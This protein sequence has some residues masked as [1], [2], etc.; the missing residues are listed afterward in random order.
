MSL[1]KDQRYTDEI[2]RVKGL[3]FSILSPEE[4]TARSVCEVTA[5]EL[6]NGM[7]PVEGGLFDTRM[8]VI[9]HGRVCRTCEQRNVTCPGHFGSI[10]LARPVHYVQFFDTV[11]KLLRCV[12]FRCS[13]LLVDTE[14]P[15][16]KALLSKK[17]SRQK[18]WDSMYRLI[19]T[20]TLRC[21]T[22]TLDGCGAMQ[23]NKITKEGVLKIVMEWTDKDEDTPSSSN[24]QQVARKLV[25]SAEDVLRILRR[26]T[27]T[28][29]DALG[30]SPKYSRPEW[31][32]C[33]VL[34]VPPPAVRP[35]VRNEGG[36]RC[37]DDLT[38]CLLHIVK[39][40]NTLK[41]KIE[42]GASKEQV[43]ILVTLLQQFVAALIDNSASGTLPLTQRT[44]RPLRALMDRLKGKEGRIRGNLVG[45]RV[46]HSA[47]SVITPDPNISIDELGVPLKIAM[48]LTYPE[49][50][51]A[52]N[53]RRLKELVENGPKT[54][55][56]AKFLRK[57]GD[58]RVISLA[59]VPDRPMLELEDGDVV[60]RHLQNGDYVLFNRQPSLHKMSMMAHRVRVMPYH[61]FRLNVCVTPTFNADFDGD[62]MNMHVPQSQQTH[63]ELL[64]LAAVPK[65]IITPR[66]SKPIISVVQDITVGVYKMTQADVRLSEKAMFNLIAANPR[67]R[68]DILPSISEKNGGRRVW[69]GR[70]VLS[71]VLPPG[72]NLEMKNNLYEN[73]PKDDNKVVVRNGRIVQG[74]FDKSVF[75]AKTNGLVHSIF[76]ENG[77]EETRLFFD[78]T[79]KLICDWLAQYG[80]SVGISDLIVDRDTLGKVK[81]IIGDAKKNVYEAIWKVHAG[82]FENLST[83]TNAGQ[84][85]Q[86]VNNEIL[87]QAV[88]KVGDIARK[89]VA[90]SANRMLDMI[91]SQAKGNLINFAQMIG[92]LGQQTV[93]G[94]RIQYGFE[95]RTLPHFTKF[96]DSPDAR[97]FVSNSF[98]SGLTPEEFFFHAM[99]GREGLIDTAVKSVTGDTPILVIDDGVPK[100]V[101][102]GEWIDAKLAA[103][104]DAVKHFPEDRNL[105]LLDVDGVYIPTT[106]ENGNVTWADL[107]A[108]TRHDPGNKLFRVETESG[109]MVIVPESKSLLVWDASRRGFYEKPTEE[110]HVGE[111]MPVTAKLPEPPVIVEHVEMEQYF[112][113][114]EYI[115]GTE[116]WKAVRCHEEALK[117]PT[118]KKL[119]GCKDAGDRTRVPQGWWEI[120]NGKE[121]VLP[122]P[123]NGMLLRA[124][125]RSNMENLK[126]GCVYPFSANR[127][128]ARLPERFVLD[129]DFGVFI[130][131]Y[132][133]DGCCCEKSG[134]VSISKENDDVRQ[135]VQAWFDKHGVTWQ[136]K[137][138]QKLRGVTT[139]IEGNSTLLA[140]FLHMF[141]GRG[142]R[143]KHVPD[144]AFVAPQDFVM[145]LLSGYFS[146]DGCV[147]NGGVNASSAS[148]RLI[149]GI[150]FLCTR[151]GVFG[152]TAVTHATTTN[153]DMDVKDIAPIHTISIRAQWAHKF[154]ATIKLVEP[155]K[156]AN[157][158]TLNPVASSKKYSQH[159]DVIVDRIV[160]IEEVDMAGYPKLY[161]VTVP[162]TLNF[163]LANGLQVQDTSESGYLQRKLVKAMEDLK[164]CHDYT[165]RDTT[166]SIVQF[167]FG[168]D[169]V[170]PIRRENQPVWY[171]DKDAPAIMAEYVFN[172]DVKLDFEHV[173]TKDALKRALDTRKEW[174]LRVWQQY[175]D[176]RE[177]R[178][179][180]IEDVFKGKLETKISYPI[181]FRRI[182]DNVKN[183]FREYGA[184]AVSDLTPLDV[185][186]AVDKLAEELY[187][188]KNNA[189]NR[190]LHLLLRCHLAP[191]PVICKHRFNK[192]SLNILLTQIRAR[193]FEGLAQP[194]EMVGVVAAQSIGEPTTQLSCSGLT[195]VLVRKPDGTM[196]YGT[197]KDLIDG[198]LKANA[199]GVVDLGG[200]SV[201]LDM[202]QA[203]D[204]RIVGVSNQ[205]KTS[206]RR[207]SQVSRHPAN[208]GMVRVHT[209]S[210]KSTCATLSHSFLKRTE[211]SIIPVLGSDLKEGDRIPV[212][213]FI[214]L[215]NETSAVTVGD[216]QMPLNR[217]FGWICG[218]YIA[219]GWISGNVVNISKKIPE[220]YERIR[221][222][223]NSLGCEMKQAYHDNTGIRNYFTHQGLARFLGDEFGRGAFNKHIPGW[224]FSSQKEFIAG[225]LG[226]YFDGDGNVN[227]HLGKQMIRAASVSKRLSDDIILLLSYFGVF[228]S[229]SINYKNKVSRKIG[230]DRVGS[231]ESESTPSDQT[232]QSPSQIKL[233]NGDPQSD[234]YCPQIS[235]KYAP[236]FKEHIGFVVHHKA[237]SLD[238][239][240]AYLD[241]E[242]V[243]DVSEEIDKIPCLGEIIATIG[244]A[245]EYPQ[246]SRTFKRWL[247]KESIGR[248]TLESYI[249]LFED[250]AH[251]LQNSGDLTAVLDNPT[252]SMEAKKQ[253]VTLLDERLGYVTDKDPHGPTR[254]KR[255]TKN[256]KLAVT[257][258]PE[259]YPLITK[260]RQAAESDVIWDEIIK[261]EYLEDPKEYVYDFTVP[262][263]D[264]FMVDCGVL[265][266]NTLNSFHLSGY[267][268]ASEAVRGVPRLKELLQVSKAIKTPTMKVYLKPDYSQDKAKAQEIKNAL[269]TT[270]L[271]DLVTSSSVF[272]DPTDSALPEDKPFIDLYREWRAENEGMCPQP[273]TSPW[274]LRLEFDRAKMLDTQMTMI[275]VERVLME[276]DKL[277]CIFSD[278]NAQQLVARIRLVE[279]ED[280]NDDM[281]MELKALEHSLMENMAVKGV[282]G[283]SKTAMNRRNGPKG[284]GI[285]MFDTESDSF[286]KTYEWLIDTAGTNLQEVLANPFVDSGRTISNDIVE[287]YGVLGI[288]ATRQALYDE[289]MEVLSEAYVN[290]CHVALLVDV[291]TNKGVLISVNRHGI[292]RTDIGPL[293]KSSFE[294]TNDVLVKAGVFAEHDRMTGV[295]ANVMLGQTAKYGTADSDVFMDA[296]LLTEARP[297]QAVPEGSEQGDEDSGMVSDEDGGQDIGE[298]AFKLGLD[299]EI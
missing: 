41:Q 280:A 218:A 271:R 47:R 45:K 72:V 193:F 223:A 269:E 59:N 205:E 136:D 212:A 258:L 272:Y 174:E 154:A 74:I 61:T 9:D 12:C 58:G 232:L 55:P 130:G 173:L 95:H 284:Q 44:G 11:K 163:G 101:L 254:I 185:L 288:E 192:A 239:I 85:E 177:D 298:D 233:K 141:V 287:I 103:A 274:V 200:N 81:E 38:H 262:G 14:R 48:N 121:F 202:T 166:G 187:V 210:G 149:E 24:N 244:D 7:M 106:D 19:T 295:S 99:G 88:K 139:S 84:F 207:I 91:Q 225:L 46:D 242:D 120:V 134:K 3:Q 259:V 292:N 62:E 183:A 13:K 65:Q 227:G 97:G 133:A 79:Q 63:E 56:G 181:A 15:E 191:K 155:N 296:E 178:R 214:P 94:K 203:D 277:S 4:I 112:P 69:T 17:V 197:I 253:V 220:F 118:T 208:G 6:F 162:S 248:R 151:L 87:N 249:T 252:A 209:K 286:D 153:L 126:E 150:S 164:I 261:L 128:A 264:S 102:I 297:L 54:Y 268:G 246:K 222:F 111:C 199:Q 138:E 40:N 5:T 32:V 135:F 230:G 124:L 50:V 285:D 263:N 293:A 33:T 123:R 96:D 221:D 235:R 75:Q 165:V 176:I 57:R 241:R 240:I 265:V 131:I 224:V 219:D 80:F 145:G 190:F 66:E 29:A 116:F 184:D 83:K 171:L 267:S 148:Q 1:Y 34:P 196:Y 125:R 204:Y 186:D 142:A 110:V 194:G 82:A 98:I 43:D 257:R 68:L 213:K 28:D 64:Q 206:W 247:K 146:G 188:C 234:Q 273:S 93:D 231:F 226:G 53:R 86:V 18:R 290:Y 2:D 175:L 49:I 198:M 108:V 119:E 216:A 167:L 140:K 294:M 77:S 27:D 157:L 161:D 26:I 182:I 283:I 238:D 122:Y 104:S 42:K 260:L 10:T 256:M 114:T 90:T 100:R 217:M 143:N 52:L 276:Y 282:N 236:L 159:N 291:M 89:R 245:L 211:S 250:T 115:H 129:R 39:T 20:K 73:D 168:E 279:N 30:F 132:L 266:H 152:K 25:L 70:D 179:F 78:N 109:R 172:D 255:Y 201:V 21:G 270:Y 60:D 71:S 180:L 105:E 158:S 37:E 215:L 92:C 76:N 195:N 127:C 16:V 117:Q 22:Q 147:R 36:Q 169:G 35:S 8:G 189:G 113:K 299:L 31:M 51:N 243:H 23:P 289:I 278:D 170:D 281:L 229:N 137:K 144:V 67:L 107:T 156:Q 228:A 275:D 237:A 160:S 251:W